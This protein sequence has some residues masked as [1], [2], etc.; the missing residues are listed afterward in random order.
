M[1]GS[2]EPIKQY[3]R[4]YED[5]KYK[6]YEVKE[7][8]SKRYSLPFHRPKPNVILRQVEMHKITLHKR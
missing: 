4:E 6:M 1:H 5:S 3:C 7:K 2:L 8:L